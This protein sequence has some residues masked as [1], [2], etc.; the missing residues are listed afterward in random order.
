MQGI[1]KIENIKTGKIYIGSSK[2]IKSRFYT[3]K[4][5]L[6]KGTHHSYKLQKSYTKTKDK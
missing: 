3:H 1:Y 5:E 6:E 2:N 4:R